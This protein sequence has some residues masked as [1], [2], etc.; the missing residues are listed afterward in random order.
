MAP[1]HR[2]S[3]K[4]SKLKKLPPRKRNGKGK[5]ISVENPEVSKNELNYF[6]KHPKVARI[7]IDGSYRNGVGGIGIFWG[8]NDRFN[9]SRRIA[10][11]TT[12]T[13]AEY[14]AA[15]VAIKQAKKRRFDMIILYTDSQN[16]VDAMRMRGKKWEKRRNKRKNTDLIE[17]IFNAQ[18]KGG[19]EFRKVRGHSGNYGND[20]ADKLAR[21]ATEIRME[22]ALTGPDFGTFLYVVFL[23]CKLKTL[24]A[25]KSSADN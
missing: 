14:E 20:Q 4:P 21:A 13:R 25:Q 11:Q 8:D 5:Q 19:V 6:R 22:E 7:Y 2:R 10:G 15:L 3:K 12:C 23:F 17:K 9:I 1:N 16:L 24:L 18:K